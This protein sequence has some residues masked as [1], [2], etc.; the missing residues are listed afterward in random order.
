MP[1][2][3]QSVALDSGS[4]TRY[5]SAPSY[6]AIR[7]PFRLFLFGPFV[8]LISPGQDLMVQSLMLISRC[9]EPALRGGAE[10]WHVFNFKAHALS[11][12]FEQGSPDFARIVRSGISSI[13]VWHM[14]GRSLECAKS[15][16][17]S[18]KAGVRSSQKQVA[19]SVL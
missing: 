6:A 14:P 13:L 7:P 2:F 9:D 4:T 18:D 16:R 5:R 19:M 3:S 8:W 12:G 11:A 17:Y 1:L 15:A 10:Q